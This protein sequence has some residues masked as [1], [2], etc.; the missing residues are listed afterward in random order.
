MTKAAITST[1][2]TVATITVTEIL[3]RKLIDLSQVFRVKEMREGSNEHR[4]F[5]GH[6]FHYSTKDAKRK[7]TYWRSGGRKLDE[8]KWQI[9]VVNASAPATALLNKFL[10][11]QTQFGAEENL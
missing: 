9:E 2:V 11:A 1:E 10:L 5:N 7:F 8:C 6:P 3:V 4:M